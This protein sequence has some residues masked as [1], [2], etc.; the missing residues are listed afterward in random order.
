MKTLFQSLDQIIEDELKTKFTL[1]FLHD[2]GMLDE[3]A[4][5]MWEI[6]QANKQAY[7]C[8]HKNPDGSDAT[9]DSVGMT[10]CRI[11]GADDFIGDLQ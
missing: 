10:S 3:T 1:K 7:C 4:V 8:N 9:F 2:H 6:E 11:C 5:A